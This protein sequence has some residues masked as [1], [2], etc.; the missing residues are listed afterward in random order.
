MDYEVI[1]ELKKHQEEVIVNEVASQLVSMMQQPMVSAYRTEPDF[2]DGGTE[3]FFGIFT[4]LE[5]AKT[6]T[7]DYCKQHNLTGTLVFTTYVI[8]S[9]PEDTAVML[10]INLDEESGDGQ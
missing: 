6:I 8:G 7:L 5:S 9:V 4:N 2:G 1:E 3:E 10:A